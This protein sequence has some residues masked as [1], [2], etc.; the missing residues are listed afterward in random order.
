MFLG[1]G[2]VPVCRLRLPKQLS[3]HNDYILILMMENV[4]AVY[5]SSNIIYLQ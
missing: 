3:L 2:S 4:Q 5:R 1:I